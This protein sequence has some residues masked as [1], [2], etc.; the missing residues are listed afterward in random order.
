MRSILWKRL[1][2]N[3]FVFLCIMLILGTV[4]FAK[5]PEKP[6]TYIIAFSPGGESD[7]TARFQQKYLEEELGVN[8]LISY[9]P[10]GGGAIAWSELARSKPDGY[11]I[12]GVNEPHTILQP[13][14]GDPGYKTED[15]TRIG[16]FQYTPDT[17]VVRA[18]SP[19]KTMQDLIDY[20]KANP[21]TLTIGGVGTWSA[22]YFAYLLL[23]KEAK[24]NLVY[25]PFAG[26]GQ[27]KPALLGGHVSATFGFPN[28]AVELGDKIRQLAV[29]SSERVAEFPDVPTLQEL[30]YN[31]IMGAYR[32]VVAPPGTPKEI[33]DILDSAFKKVSENPEFIKQMEALGFSPFYWGAEE[34]SKEIKEGIEYYKNLLAEYGY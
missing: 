23:S 21:G 14:Q 32:G 13:L 28:Q 16:C 11:T 9:K 30:G 2:I 19:F 22:P 31:V 18:D 6:I 7:I 34:Y 25:V 4:S 10:G 8:I 12:A 5:Y 3:G 26:S 27:T 1:V 29:A 24:I 33:V 17:I 20:A 15:L